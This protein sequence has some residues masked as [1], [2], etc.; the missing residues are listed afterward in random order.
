MYF[1]RSFLNQLYLTGLGLSLFFF[2]LDFLAFFV[3]PG[4]LFGNIF[5]ATRE[6]TP[7]TWLS[8]IT[9]LLLALGTWS[10]AFHTREWYWRALT[11]I[12]LF[13]S[14]D[15]AVYLHERIAGFFREHTVAL[16]DFP[17]YVWMI[18]YAPLLIFA[19]GSLLL[20]LWRRAHPGFRPWLISIFCLLAVAASFDS[21][22]GWFQQGNTLAL[23]STETC[24]RIFLHSLRLFEE[25]LEVWAIGLLGYIVASTWLVS[26][27]G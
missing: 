26:K 13:F 23:C 15:D 20:V 27:E 24:T 6:Q 10:V 7:L 17:S 9:F 18:L 8:A 14:I 22:D 12:F 11:V 2:L 16:H 1:S 25:M 5:T 21:L 4:T 3:F 19:L